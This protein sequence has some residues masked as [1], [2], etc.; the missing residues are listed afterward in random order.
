MRLNLDRLAEAGVQVQ[1]MRAIGGGAKSKV[2]MQLK[3]DIFDRPVASLNVSEGACLGAAILVGVGAG[4]YP[5]ASVAAEMAR[6][7]EVFEPNPKAAGRYQ[8]RYELYRDLYPTLRDFN[9]RL[10]ALSD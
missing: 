10:A 6:E 5:D 1:R 7:V 3:A 8:E 2:W 4:V 9:H